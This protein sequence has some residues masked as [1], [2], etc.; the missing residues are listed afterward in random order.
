MSSSDYQPVGA[1][2]GKATI[3]DLERIRGDS[4]TPEAFC[5]KLAEILHV[6][7]N[8]VALLR[9]EKNWLRFVFPLELRAAG[10]LP[11]SGPAV[12]AR[13]ASAKSS[14]L[15]NSFARVR[16]AS[17]F[18]TVRLGALEPEEPGSQQMPIQKIM[19]VPVVGSDGQVAGVI[20]VSRKGLDPTLAGADFTSDDLRLLENAAQIVAGLPFMRE[21][22]DLE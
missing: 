18:E 19:S 17:L 13:T 3:A 9:V 16:H 10:A 2:S 7:S 8:E 6:H 20:Q 15:S 21:G 14:L 4:P 1:Q 11:L 5:L 12:A 22:A